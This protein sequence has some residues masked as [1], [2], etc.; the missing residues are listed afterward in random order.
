MTFQSKKKI[1]NICTQKYTYKRHKGETG[2]TQKETPTPI[3]IKTEK[4]FTQTGM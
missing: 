2:V 3:R 4:P 1:V